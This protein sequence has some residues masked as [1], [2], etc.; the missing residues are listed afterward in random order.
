MVSKFVEKFMAVGKNGGVTN[1]DIRKADDLPNA[2]I[3]NPDVDNAD[4]QK[5]NGAPADAA[6]ADV[7]KAARSALRQL[8]VQCEW[9]EEWGECP[10]MDTSLLRRCT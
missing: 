10:M 4:V 6:K 2:N 7:E 5:D 3:T 1:T 9:A 8:D